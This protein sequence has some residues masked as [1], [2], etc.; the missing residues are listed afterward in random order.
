[1]KKVHI[2]LESWV[3]KAQL[4]FVLRSRKERHPRSFFGMDGL[5]A[6]FKVRRKGSL[7]PGEH[8]ETCWMCA[9]AK[10]CHVNERDYCFVYIQ[11]V[12]RVCGQGWEEFPLK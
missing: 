9:E 10:N 7:G 1:M 3:S 5:L 12:L 6:Q 2:G 8:A 4:G 11:S